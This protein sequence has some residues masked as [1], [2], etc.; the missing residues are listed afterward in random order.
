MTLGCHEGFKRAAQASL[1]G[2]PSFRSEPALERSEGMTGPQGALLPEAAEYQI[3]VLQQS[4][5]WYPQG[6]VPR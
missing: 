3:E 4:Q 2:D 5:T 6:A 1:R